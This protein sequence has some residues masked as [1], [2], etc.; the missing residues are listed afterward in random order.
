MPIVAFRQSNAVVPAKRA[1][2]IECVKSLEDE[3]RDLL[4]PMDYTWLKSD[5]EFVRRLMAMEDTRDARELIRLAV[6]MLKA[7]QN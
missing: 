7:R 1:R 3:I 6:L 4:I 5:P 2:T